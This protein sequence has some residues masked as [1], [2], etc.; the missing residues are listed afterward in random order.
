MLCKI[1]LSVI[2]VGVAFGDED[3]IFKIRK[4]CAENEIVHEM[5]GSCIDSK[6]YRHRHNIYYT[7]NETVI[8]EKGNP[9]KH[10][11]TF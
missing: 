6:L 11:E 7:G 4:C 1:F 9:G 8:G 10:I 2:F 3:R 5:T